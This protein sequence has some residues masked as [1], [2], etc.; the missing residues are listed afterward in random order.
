MLERAQEEARGLR[1]SYIGTEHILLALL[2]EPGWASRRLVEARGITHGTVR[3]KVVRMM[4][5]GVEADPGALPFTARGKAAVDA[6]GEEASAAGDSEVRPDHV[7]LALIREPS[8]A[9]ARILLDLYVDVGELRGEVLH[10]LAEAE[11]SSAA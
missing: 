11:D 9:S 6:A 3:A 7:L 5:T 8:D 4:G 10:A 2:D 1:H